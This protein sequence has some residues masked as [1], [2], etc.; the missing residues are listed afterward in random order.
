MHL[1]IIGGSGRTGKLLIQA[2]LQAKYT[3]T[4]LVRNPASL[5]PSLGLSIVQG[6]PE[7]TTDIST[8]ISSSPVKPDA[9]IVALASL[10]KT[11][12]PFSA[13][14]SS[15]TFMTDVHILLLAEMK[16]SGILRLITISAFGVGDSNE[17][18]IWPMR[19]LMNRSPMAV[20]VKDHEGVEEVVRRAGKDDGL[21][22]TLVKPCMLA[23]GEDGGE[24]LP[25]KVLGE[26]GEGAG[27]MPS[28]TRRSVAVWVVRVALDEV[29]GEQWIGKTPVLAN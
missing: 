29:D 11:D 15:P 3:I 19:M 23:G 26:K 28:V 22:W 5:T 20:G 12:S 18:L 6:S 25:V 10:R 8:A 21:R 7:K 17:S 4:A 14:V 24:E 27:C 2:A 1:L 16:K 13:P 9:V